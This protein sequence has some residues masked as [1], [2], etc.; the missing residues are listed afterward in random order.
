MAR[1]A[2]ELHDSDL[3]VVDPMEALCDA[4]SCHAVIDGQLMYRDDNHL[5]DEGA[6]LVWSRIRPDGL[7][8]LTRYAYLSTQ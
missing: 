7:P 5:T 3:H 4:R 2:A 8:P 6:R 1:V